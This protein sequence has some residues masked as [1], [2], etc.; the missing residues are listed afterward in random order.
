MITA[1]IE[2][3]CTRC[4]ESVTR[5]LEI[6]FRDLFVDASRE[7][8]QRETELAID[9][10]DESLV[11]GGRIDLAEVVREQIL[12]ALPEQV[13]CREDCRGLCP[14]CGGNRNLIDCSCDRDEID[15]RWAA[16]KNLN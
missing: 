10:M 3:E 9:D 11:I 6:P 1:K 7:T 2:T 5:T 15:P 4:L 14:K 8:T 12:L 16:L 13:L